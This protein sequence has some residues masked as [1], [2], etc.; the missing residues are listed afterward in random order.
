MP[1]G[2]H[3]KK[4]HEG[5]LTAKAERHG[6]SDPLGF[7]HHVLANKGKHDA[8]TIKQAQFAVNAS[9]WAH[10]PM[11]PDKVKEYEDYRSDVASA[12]KRHGRKK[13]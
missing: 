10:R 11:H 3:I 12:V 7:A 8:A 5:L 6:F 13:R 2:I 9:H 1:D 4:S